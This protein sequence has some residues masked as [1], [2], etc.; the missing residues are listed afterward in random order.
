MHFTLEFEISNF[1]Q[2]F[3]N[4]LNSI[5]RRFQ[6]RDG[7]QNPQNKINR[8]AAQDHYVGAPRRVKPE[9][10][11]GERKFFDQRGEHH[12][13]IPH[14]IAAD[15]QEYDLKRDRDADKP[16]EIFGMRDRGRIILPDFL[17]Q[18]KLRQEN[19]QT[20]NS[21]RVKCVFG[22]FHKTFIV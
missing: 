20:V 13:A 8:R 10:D 7:E 11:N 1:K 2:S 16:V 18:K 14:G 3:S 19:D 9:N 12:R 4:F 21:R 15:D 5:L 6:K 17:Q 22:K